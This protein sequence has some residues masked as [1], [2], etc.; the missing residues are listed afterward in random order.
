MR[1]KVLDYLYKQ[2]GLTLFAFSGE[3]D[4]PLETLQDTALAL[5]AG[6]RFVVVDFSG[7]AETVGNIYV[8]DLLERLVTKQELDS[9]GEGSCI[10]SGN[11]L[12]PTNDDQFR[13]L[14]HNL[15]LIQEY[16]PQ[17]LGIVPMDMNHE[18]A[19]YIP[20]VT[21]L[22]VIAG[23]DMDFACEQI[24]DLKGL[25]QTNILWL[26][27]E[28]PNKK[29]FPRAAATINAS[30]SFTKECTV[31]KTNQAWK[32]N[33]KSFGSTIESLHKVQILQK[34]PLDGIPKLFRKFYPI[35]LIIAVL[36]PFLFVSKLEPSVSNTRNRIHERDIITTAPSFE[37]TFD[38]KE[39]VNRVARYGIGR[40]C[41]LVA[42]EKMVKQYMDVTLDENGYNANAWTKENNQIIPPAGTVIKF[43]RP[44]MFNETSAD[45]TGSAWKYWTS[46]YSDSIA[47]LTEFYYENQT[48]TNRKHQA[49]DVAGK[50]GARILAPFSAKAWTSKD[51]RGGII[52]GLVHE[53]QVVV[54]M[55]CDKLLYLDGQEVMAGDPIATVG[56]SGH[57]TGPHAHIVTGIVDKNGTK[58][59]GNIKYKVMD[60]ITWYY[61]FKPKSLK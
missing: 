40:F 12:L 14:Y 22:L 2:G 13:N 8:N 41:A 43:S 28:K 30:Q 51:E 57:T 10:I 5:N 35:F 20:L 18:E 7:K 6:A 16:V 26:F 45:S 50:Q 27:N 9:L 15:Q 33:P 59:L 25:Q 17:I 58:R 42:D 3:S 55:H 53:K 19:T 1:Y 48:Q 52:I 24:E 21:R 23:K 54:F 46:I 29:R 31:L 44:D 49:I 61:R 47:Y 4:L 11:R 38:G 37:Y 36:I 34:N 39:S 60:P 32:K 56:T